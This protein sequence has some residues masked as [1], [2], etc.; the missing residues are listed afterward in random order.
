M[1]RQPNA[2]IAAL[3]SKGEGRNEI[4]EIEQQFGR[5]IGLLQNS[6]QYGKLRREVRDAVWRDRLDDSESHFEGGPDNTAST[7]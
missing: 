2:V 5:A 7:I 4:I 6:Y 1:A 3:F